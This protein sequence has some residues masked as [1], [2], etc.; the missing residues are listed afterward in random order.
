M[1]LWE[2][3]LEAARTM[4][5]HIMSIGMLRDA[6]SATRTLREAINIM[7]RDGPWSN[8]GHQ[9]SQTLDQ[10]VRGLAPSIPD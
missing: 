10:I 5:A 2:K 3:W 6:N 7:R 9:I 1:Q 8:M 4:D